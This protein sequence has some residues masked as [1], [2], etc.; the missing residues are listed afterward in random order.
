MIDLQ[1]EDYCKDC[2]EFKVEQDTTSLNCIGF[3]ETVH[4]LSCEHAEKC[5]ALKKYLEGKI[6]K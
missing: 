6:E 5:K 4:T 1:I 3:C 2:N